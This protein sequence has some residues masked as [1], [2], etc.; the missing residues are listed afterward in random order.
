L[1]VEKTRIEANPLDRVQELEAVARSTPSPTVRAPTGSI[2]NGVAPL[3]APPTVA[4]KA[5]RFPSSRTC[6]R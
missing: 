5:A 1:P 4:G 3:P 2:T 6:R